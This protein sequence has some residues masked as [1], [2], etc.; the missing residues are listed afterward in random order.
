MHWTHRHTT[1]M[2]S[3]FIHLLQLSFEAFASIQV[4]NYIVY[5]LC[6]FI[7]YLCYY[8]FILLNVFK[9]THNLILTFW[10][11]H[12]LKLTPILSFYPQHFSVKNEGQIFSQIQLQIRRTI[13]WPSK[14]CSIS[15]VRAKPGRRWLL[16]SFT[17]CVPHHNNATLE[18]SENVTNSG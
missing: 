4:E 18:H 3:D 15:V 2:A 7:L 6:Y 12:A 5:A 1:L 11:E 16:P 9:Y 14:C 17:W 8:I 10:L 13:Q